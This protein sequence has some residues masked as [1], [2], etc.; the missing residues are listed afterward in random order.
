MTSSDPQNV[1]ALP[2]G[3]F[4]VDYPRIEHVL[5]LIRLGSQG[6]EG[7]YDSCII[8][9]SPPNPVPIPQSQNGIEIT[10]SDTARSAP[11]NESHTH[12]QT[13]TLA[14]PAGQHGKASSIYDLDTSTSSLRSSSPY[15][16]SLNVGSQP[17][18][19]AGEKGITTS[20][21]MLNSQLAVS[22]GVQQALPN[23]YVVP[24]TPETSVST[25]AVQ[26]EIHDAEV[27][28]D[29]DRSTPLNESLGTPHGALQGSSDGRTSTPGGTAA[30]SISSN[31]QTRPSHLGALGIEN[32]NDCGASSITVDD[33]FCPVHPHL[34]S[35]QNILSHKYA[36]ELEANFVMNHL[37]GNASQSLDGAMVDIIRQGQVRVWGVTVCVCV[38]VGGG[39]GGVLILFL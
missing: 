18:A 28:A 8:P 27:T 23:P 7:G 32:S 21:A 6:K 36:Q 9:S 17:D 5:Q 24:A 33:S 37:Y 4:D 19:N 30:D 14:I 22:E 29:R 39:G 26:V 31:L 15:F 34:A 25:V 11:L 20:R 35:P 38:C 10:V 13:H 1:I 2:S 3:K 16:L 12:V